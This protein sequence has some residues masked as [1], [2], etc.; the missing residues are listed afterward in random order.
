MPESRAG[1]VVFDQPIP[2]KGRALLAL[3]VVRR[4]ARQK[5]NAR[6]ALEAALAGFEALG[7]ASWVTVARAELARI[8]GR[9]RVEG[10]SP[11]ELAVAKLVVEG[12]TNREIASALFLSQTTVASHLS[13]IYA[14][15]GVR[16]RAELMRQMLPEGQLPSGAA[17]KVHTS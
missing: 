8:G 6:A 12:L 10:L 16:S 5:R 9:Q 17:S 14:K 7:A 13:H 4:R 2:D 3:G 11:S 15:L 1:N